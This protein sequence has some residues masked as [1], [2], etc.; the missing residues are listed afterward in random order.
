[1]KEL[2]RSAYNHMKA[3]VIASRDQLCMRTDLRDKPNTDKI[4][5]CSSLVKKKKCEYYKNVENGLKAPELQENNILDI[6][7][8]SRIGKKLQC[9]PFYVSKE[10][11][12]RADIVFMPYNYLLDPNIR[13]ATQLNLKNAIVIFDEAHNVEKVCEQSAS[14]KITSEQIDTAIGNAIY[15]SI[16]G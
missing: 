10:L 5:I 15:V 13:K 16:S 4:D 11:R 6:E 7:E 2:K 3:G 12:K 9:C 1:M 8:L 14:T